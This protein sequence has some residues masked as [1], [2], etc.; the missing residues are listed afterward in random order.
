MLRAF[1]KEVLKPEIGSRLPIDSL[2]QALAVYLIRRYTDRQLANGQPS[3]MP[4]WRI[5]RQIFLVLVLER[6]IR[7]PELNA[8]PP[9]VKIFR[10]TRCRPRNAFPIEHEDEHEEILGGLQIDQLE[11]HPFTRA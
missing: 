2:S 8:G 3:V 6:L 10:H 4:K 5:R 7:W 9:T 1:Q 11:P